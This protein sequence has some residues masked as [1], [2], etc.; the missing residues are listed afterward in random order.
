MR[1][2]LWWVYI[3]PYLAN[4]K[5]MVFAHPT[6]QEYKYTVL[7]KLSRRP[8]VSVWSVGSWVRMHSILCSRA[9]QIDTKRTSKSR[10]CKIW[11]FLKKFL[12]KKYP[13][14]QWNQEIFNSLKQAFFFFE[15]K[16]K[17]SKPFKRSL[18][19]RK[20][21]KIKYWLFMCTIFINI[22]KF[23]IQRLRTI[24]KTFF[25]TSLYIA[26]YLIHWK[27]TSQNIPFSGGFQEISGKP[28]HEIGFKI[29]LLPWNLEHT[30]A[31][32]ELPP[33]VEA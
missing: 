25:L 11:P 8:N 17:K 20:Q 22:D 13:S 23:I 12:V 3:L 29:P 19:L 14:L 27:P 4:I 5:W 30:S 6:M 2:K 15:I 1:Y 31:S 21:K 28:H 24:A 26:Q 16:K 9:G 32:N 10:A 33:E 7:S 18:F